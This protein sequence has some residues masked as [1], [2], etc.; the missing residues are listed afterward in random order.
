VTSE[1][2]TAVPAI[3]P[4]L[5]AALEGFVSHLRLERGLS[6]NTVL[7][8]ERD[9]RRY[10]GLLT[11][12]GASGLADATREDLSALLSMLA[13]IGMEASSV[14]R[15]LTAVRTFHRF[16]LSEGARG[17]DPTEHV[18]PPKVRRK[19]PTVLGVADVER[20]LSQPDVEEA[21]GLRDRALLELLYGAGLR[22]SELTELVSGQLLF[23]LGVVRVVGKGSKERIVPVGSEAQSWM[24]RYGQ[25]GRPTLANPTSGDRVFLN[26]RGRKL[27]RMGVWKLLK[28]HG[29]AAGL[30][31]EISPHT[32][33]HSFATHLLEG[34]ADLRA[35]Q[36]MLGHQ[37]IS[38]T[39]IY[40]HIDRDYLREVHRSFHP[41]A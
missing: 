36:E 10:L 23:N 11:E 37:D 34:G 30:P 26:H 28:K 7:S 24:Q 5:T 22:V 33:R 12:R 39:Q 14:A 27:S 38:T 16:H 41:R 40:T 17:D 1:A 19:L 20:L 3:A 18:T 6:E 29:R 2:S 9:V 35:V 32:L 31:G 25:E 4:A 21:L 15:N 8:Y 13:D